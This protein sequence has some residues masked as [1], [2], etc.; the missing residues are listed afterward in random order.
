MDD[1]G[2]ST[3]S[4]SD[5]PIAAYNAGAV[6][7]LYRGISL[8]GIAMAVGGVLAQL[9]VVEGEVRRGLMAVSD[10]PSAALS[11]D[12]AAWTTLGIW[13]LLAGPA[14]A[15]ISMFISGIR[16]RSWPAVILSAVVL[17]IL[18]LAVPAMYWLEGGV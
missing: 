13:V 4:S 6:G 10:V 14:L 1:D 9:F 3:E 5:P 12:P 7:W 2:Q 8:V 11:G 17:V 16:R 18:L 15:L